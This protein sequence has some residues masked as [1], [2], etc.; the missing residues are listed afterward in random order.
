MSKPKRLPAMVGE[1][2]VRFKEKGRGGGNRRPTRMIKIA[3]PNKWIAFARH[4]WVMTYG[5]PPAGTSIRHLN[6]DTLD[7]RIENLRPFTSGGWINYCHQHRPAM[8][9]ENRTGSKR[10]DA[11]REFNRATAAAR[12]HL[13]FLPRYWYAINDEKR[14]V[15]NTPYKSRR[16]LLLDRGVRVS[17]N[18]RI[19]NGVTLDFAVARGRELNQRPELKTYKRIGNEPVNKSAAGQPTTRQAIATARRKLSGGL[20]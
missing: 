4:L 12:R 11:V 6:F 20:R 19:P 7:D 17:L 5:E 3:E 16:R 1:T 9:S 2:R 13:E 8:S 18:G 15:W 14:I 10:L